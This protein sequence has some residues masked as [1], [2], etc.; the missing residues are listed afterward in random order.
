MGIKKRTHRP[1][2]FTCAMGHD[3]YHAHCMPCT[4]ALRR[5]VKLTYQAIGDDI[6]RASSE[7]MDN[8]AWIEVLVDR[9]ASGYNATTMDTWNYI[10]SA[11]DAGGLRLA[12]KEAGPYA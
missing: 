1:E 11:W 2:P 10:K 9:I 3:R 5:I 4:L 6:Q 12:A 8:D 7:P